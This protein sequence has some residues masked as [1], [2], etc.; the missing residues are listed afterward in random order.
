MNDFMKVWLITMALIGSAAAVASTNNDAPVLQFGTAAQPPFG[1]AEAQALAN[2]R[3][4]AM[5]G[6]GQAVFKEKYGQVWTFRT[7]LGYGGTPGPD[8]TIVE[9]ASASAGANLLLDPQAPAYF[10]DLVGGSAYLTVHVYDV[11]RRA[12]NEPVVVRDRAQL[13]QLAQIFARAVFQPTSH[14]LA[15]L[16][17]GPIVFYGADKHRMLTLEPFGEVVRLNGQDYRV[18][19]T[20]ATALAEWLKHARDTAS[21][22][23]L[24]G[25]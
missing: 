5:F 6:E 24:P 11:T 13:D 14:L 8:I 16:A 12:V 10:S 25:K 20:T 21:P 15:V 22:A 1:R 9:P 3:C 17:G 7:E 4:R 23:Q 18:G 2:A 19:K